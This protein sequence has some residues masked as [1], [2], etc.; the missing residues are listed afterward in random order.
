ML[1]ST[2]TS[3]KS[4]TGVGECLSVIGSRKHSNCASMAIGY[5][6]GMK[7]V[8]GIY[9][10]ADTVWSHRAPVDPSWYWRKINT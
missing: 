5:E 1:S 6:K 2:S 8:H 10:K 4:T 3:G 7:W 9:I